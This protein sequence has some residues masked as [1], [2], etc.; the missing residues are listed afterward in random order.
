[1]KLKKMIEILGNVNALDVKVYDFEKTS[2]F[3]DYFIVATLN[4]RQAN[5]AIN[6]FKQ[7][8][9]ESIS[10]VEGKNSGWVLIDLKDVIVHLFTKEQREY[11]HFET[12]LLEVKEINIDEL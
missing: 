9:G 6:Y 10:H 4:E 12:R 1:M 3:F 2:P 11:Y 5:A 8:F 7:E